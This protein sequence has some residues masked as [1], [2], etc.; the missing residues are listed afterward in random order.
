V[1]HVILDYSVTIYVD[2]HIYLTMAL[3]GRNMSLTKWWS[4]QWPV[5]LHWRLYCVSSDSHLT[6]S[7][8]FCYHII[9]SD[10]CFLQLFAS[11]F[12]LVFFQYRLCVINSSRDY[13]AF[14]EWIISL[15]PHTEWSKTNFAHAHWENSV[16]MSRAVVHCECTQMTV[17]WRKFEPHTLLSDERHTT[18]SYASLTL[19]GR[20][21][22]VRF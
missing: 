8:G 10:S 20:L 17:S 19:C 1:G 18:S 6:L 13:G 11:F 7:F 12:L 2:H 21:Q 15:K 22:G 14:V 4:N 16:W 9:S 5:R 3:C